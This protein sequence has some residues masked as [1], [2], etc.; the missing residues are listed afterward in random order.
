MNTI[1]IDIPVKVAANASAVVT[2]SLNWL[3]ENVGQQIDP[4]AAFDSVSTYNLDTSQ[5]E[6]DDTPLR[7]IALDNLNTYE[8]TWYTS[9][10][11]WHTEEAVQVG[12]YTYTRVLRVSIENDAMAVAFK[13]C[14]PWN[15]TNQTRT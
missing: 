11:G 3:I 14:S 10:H 4:K 1:I 13:L 6:A 8:R 9:G 5:R 2:N 15:V 12:P 7:T